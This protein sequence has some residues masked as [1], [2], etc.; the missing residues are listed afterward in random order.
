MWVFGKFCLC[1][2]PYESVRMPYGTLAGPARAL[3]GCHK[4][5]KTLK[6]PMRG[7]Y[8]ARTGIARGPCWVLRIIRSNQKCTAVS[9]RTGPVDWCDH[10]NSTGVKFL[11][12]FHLAL[13]ARSRT[14]GCWKSY[15]ACGWMWLRNYWACDYLFM[16]RLKSKPYISRMYML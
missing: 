15:E 7:R 9:C 10:E 11:W 2:F 4:I 12:A 8:D 14:S 5:W 13:R 1:Q 3:H 6:I 16:L